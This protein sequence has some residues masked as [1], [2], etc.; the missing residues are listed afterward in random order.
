LSSTK[1]LHV[2]LRGGLG[3]Q[4]FQY[5]TGLAIAEAQSR[6]LVLRGDLLP[7]VEDSIG[8]VSRW[9]NQIC[10]FRH[11]GIIRTNSNQPLNRT[12]LF[13]KWMQVMRLLGDWSPAL[14]ASLGWL[15]S[16]NGQDSEPQLQR[17]VRL[18]NSYSS[19]KAL[20]FSNRDGLRDEIILIHK[21]S[22]EFLRLS[23]E[24]QESKAIALHLRQGDY[25]NLVGTYGSSS[26]DFIKSALDELLQLGSRPKIWVF[27]DT[28]SSTP[29][30]IL[31]FVTPERVIGPES[32]PRP[33][34]NMVL[35]SKANGLIAANS[36]F[37]WWT[38]FLS[39]PNTPVVAPRIASARVHIFSPGSEPDPKWRIIDVA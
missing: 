23:S 29:S 5:S 4:L 27:T 2:F 39:S 30:E 31:E 25:L 20:A 10:E 8:A 11:S 22:Q 7:D 15:A 21:P 38:A 26:L 3:N 36:T 17:P 9:P 24:I 33:I 13:S 1:E 37:S 14:V 18:I 12:N 34:E 28:P 16:E 32:I 35:M 6:S 19:A